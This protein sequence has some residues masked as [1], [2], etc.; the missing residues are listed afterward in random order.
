M[1][2]S[3]ANK[4]LIYFLLL[5]F[6]SIIIIGLYAYSQAKT[7]LFSRTFDQLTSV[8]IEKSKRVQDYFKQRTQEIQSL[9]NTV[10]Q[11]DQKTLSQKISYKNSPL[12]SLLINNNTYSH[13]YLYQNDSLYYQIK[14]KEG[15]TS[16]FPLD[17][18]QRYVLNKL[19]KTPREEVQIIENTSLIEGASE[20]LIYRSFYFENDTI[21]VAFS[22][23]LENT[24]DIMLDRNPLNGLGESGEAYLVGSDNLMRSVSRFEENSTF[25]IKVQT[26]GVQRAIED[27]IGTAIFNDYRDVK[28]LS[29]FSK[30]ELPQL[31][32][33]I[34]AEIDYEEA[35]VPIRSYGYNIIYIILLLSLLLLGVVALLS[36]TITAPLRKLRK[37]TEKI[38]LGDYSP[39]LDIKA[40]GEIKDLIQSYNRML[41]KIKEQQENLRI[42]RD[43]SISSMIDGQEIERSRLAMELHD[44]LAQTILAIKMR[45]ENTAPEKAAYV[46]H[47]SKDMFADLMHEIRSMS[48]DLMPA[49]LREFGLTKALDSLLSQ[50]E[51]NSQIQ[52]SI[53][54]K[55]DF[56]LLNKRAETYLYRIAQEATNNVLK[57]AQAHHFEIELIWNQDTIV[58]E[59]KD[60][61]VGLKSD[62][63]HQKTNGLANIQE[64]VS[65]LGGIVYFYNVEP[66]GLRI[67]CEIPLKKC[68]HE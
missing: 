35:M 63:L 18:S 56:T 48:N 30:I 9:S 67:R 50:T 36:N 1:K 6:I 13:F 4:L 53:S 46:L 31:N 57:H 43:R 15:S 59:L 49:V 61:G 8:R 37:E 40:D 55:G 66:Q 33:T 47:E 14:K 19:I 60:D 10:F 21:L 65:V 68:I 17:S 25:R 58:F 27:S 39:L 64:R 20:I 62:S 42:A 5:N 24:N 41:S 2:K 32:W 22:L 23:D 29:S 11:H 7:A 54:T 12:Q 26:E 28:V 3:L 44:G 52:T 51:S 38:S 34:M 45:L 16:L